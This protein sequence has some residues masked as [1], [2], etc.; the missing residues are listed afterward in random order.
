MSV[1]YDG[2]KPRQWIFSVVAVACWH[3]LSVSKYGFKELLS[4]KL[5]IPISRQIL[6]GLRMKTCGARSGGGGG[7]NLHWLFIKCDSNDSIERRTRSWSTL[8]KIVRTGY[9][10]MTFNDFVYAIVILNLI[11]NSGFIFCFVLLGSDK[12]Q[13]TQIWLN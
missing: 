6:K 11:I 3:T 9:I 8:E 2:E 5:E 4:N 7:T 10:R 13:E 1:H 12:R